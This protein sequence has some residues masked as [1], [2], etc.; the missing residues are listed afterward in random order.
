MLYTP[1]TLDTP[2]PFDSLVACSAVVTSPYRWCHTTIWHP[3][4]TIAGIVC[5]QIFHLAP[6]GCWT[7]VMNGPQLSIEGLWMNLIEVNESDPNNPEA[8]ASITAGTYKAEVDESI[9]TGSIRRTHKGNSYSGFGRIGSSNGANALA[10][11]HSRGARA[12]GPAPPHPLTLH[13]LPLFL[14]LARVP[15]LARPCNRRGHRP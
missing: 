15:L 2:L 14:S 5:N 13:C 1:L 4:I 10:A 3:N 6:A 9:R 7:G 12:A 8:A 11:Q